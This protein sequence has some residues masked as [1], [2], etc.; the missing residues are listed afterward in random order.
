MKKINRTA[1]IDG[2]D[3]K[4]S[5]GSRYMMILFEE[6]GFIQQSED[7]K[8]LL[9]IEKKIA[10]GL[11]DSDFY[12]GGPY[13]MVIDIHGPIHYRN[14]TFKPMDSMLYINR[15]IKKYH[16]NYLVIPYNF[17]NNILN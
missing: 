9:E 1:I 10:G 14:Q 13:D 4:I 6:L 12:L 2:D 15:I 16:K 8:P 7:G 5:R 11:L 17:Y 3:S